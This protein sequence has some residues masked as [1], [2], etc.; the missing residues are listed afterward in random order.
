MKQN[1][2]RQGFKGLKPRKVNYYSILFGYFK[3][4]P[5]IL[6]ILCLIFLI[7]CTVLYLWGVIETAH[8]SGVVSYGG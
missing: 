2:N 6:A 7:I 8:M 1:N 3:A 4:N 5:D